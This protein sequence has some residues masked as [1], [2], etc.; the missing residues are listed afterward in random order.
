MKVSMGLETL[1]KDVYLLGYVVASVIR[2]YYRRKTRQ[3]KIVENR[4]PTADALLLFLSSIGIIVLPLSYMLTPWLDWADYHLPETFQAVA[5]IIGTLIFAAA[6]W[7]LWR[8]HADLG[9]NWSPQMDVREKHT[10]V[11]QGVYRSIRHPMYAAHV[12]WGFAQPL[13]LQNWIAGWSMLATL[14]PLLWVRIPREERMMLDSFGDEY[15]S[16]M[17]RTGRLL[18]RL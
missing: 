15:R 12:L 18:P 14:L 10:L 11:T 6:I 2:A 16:Y 7:L 13:L 9:L 4:A 17:N 3:N 5:G 1:F 8:S